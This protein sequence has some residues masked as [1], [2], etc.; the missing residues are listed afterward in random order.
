MR[1]EIY[2]LGTCSIDY[3]RFYAL[4]S[5][6]QAFQNGPCECQTENVEAVPLGYTG[7]F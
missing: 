3:C 4:C 5:L 2:I 6:V 1:V 7:S